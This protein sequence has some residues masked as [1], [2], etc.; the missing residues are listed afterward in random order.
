[1]TE[2]QHFTEEQVK[3]ALEA[4]IRIAD[5]LGLEG[6]AHHATV[7]W[8]AQK[9]SEKTIMQGAPALLPMQGRIQ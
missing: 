1:M 3:E 9:L 7:L 6:D 8:A 5:A 4:G 2:L